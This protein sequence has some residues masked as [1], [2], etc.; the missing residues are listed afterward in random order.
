MV[1]YVPYSVLP[2]K[3]NSGRGLYEG[4]ASYGRI[5]QIAGGQ[6]EWADKRRDPAG[7]GKDVPAEIRQDAGTS[8]FGRFT[9]SPP[10]GA[11]LCDRC[12][13]GSFAVI[14]RGPAWSRS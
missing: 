5:T 4:Q 12:R 6:Q 9:G 8:E 7:F 1:D 3:V 13:R 11:M 2:D 10:G 14:G